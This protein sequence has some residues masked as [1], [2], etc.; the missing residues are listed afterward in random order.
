MQTSFIEHF[1]T[2]EN[3]Q[4]KKKSQEKTEITIMLK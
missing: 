1:T 2:D 4:K 3:L